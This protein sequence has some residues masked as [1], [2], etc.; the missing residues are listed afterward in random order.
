MRL[1]LVGLVVNWA[2]KIV[3][4]IL[5][6]LITILFFYERIKI[7]NNM[8]DSIE[9]NSG[10]L[11]TPL[12]SG[13][14]IKSAAASN[15]ASQP[16]GIPAG[17]ISNSFD[18]NLASSSSTS[19]LLAAASGGN[20]VGKKRQRDEKEIETR[21]GD[22]EE[23]EGE[24]EEGEEGDFDENEI[25]FDGDIEEGE[26]EILIENGKPAILKG[27]LKPHA[28]EPQSM[29]LDIADEPT[30]NNI[31][32]GHGK[33]KK[34]SGVSP[35]GEKECIGCQI[36]EKKRTKKNTVQPNGP[37]TTQVEMCPQTG[38]PMNNGET[39]VAFNAATR[40]NSCAALQKA[41]KGLLKT[42]ENFVVS[43]F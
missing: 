23:E 40:C 34:K 24:G 2:I 5:V 15:R 12:K 31:R 25:D 6:S 42:V 17:T 41:V 20:G 9:A 26:N 7:N 18:P 29:N 11:N 10:L 19:S 16:V 32:L 8:T 13:R 4:F 33:R 1:A 3:I 22:G 43:P 38:V 37:T 21:G 27:I 36:P 39:V 35:S 30:G 28:N 14:Y